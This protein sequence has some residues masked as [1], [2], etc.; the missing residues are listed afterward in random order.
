MLSTSDDDTAVRLVYKTFN[1]TVPS[2]P[3][4]DM[5]VALKM[6]SVHFV[7]TNRYCFALYRLTENRLIEEI[8]T[9]FS[10]FSKIRE[11]ISFAATKVVSATSEIVKESASSKLSLSVDVK[12]PV[13]KIP[14]LSGDKENFLSLDLGNID[15]SNA[16]T[17][18]GTELVDD[19]VIKGM[20][21]LIS[22]LSF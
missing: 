18:F 21:L 1:A 5:R 4:Y 6:A 14:I 3:G 11:I 2:Y 20:N 7:Y 9:Y 10:A 16:I 8:S 13:I 17:T 22:M 12:T 19:M 15:A